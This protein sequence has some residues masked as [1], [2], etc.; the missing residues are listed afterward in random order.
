MVALRCVCVC[1]CVVRVGGGAK[2]ILMIAVI[3]KVV[4]LTCPD[5]QLYVS[6]PPSSYTY[7]LFCN[8]HVL[9]E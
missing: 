7:M 4:Y 1:V 3:D 9:L 8:R 6:H 5:L 2:I